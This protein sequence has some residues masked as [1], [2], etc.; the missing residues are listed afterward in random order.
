MNNLTVKFWLN[1]FIPKDVFNKDGTLFSKPRP[2][3]KDETMIPGPITNVPV[4]LPL[5]IP[6]PPVRVDFSDCFTTDNRGFSSDPGASSRLHS[7]IWLS[8]RNGIALPGQD[9]W[10]HESHEVDCED[11][12]LEAKGKGTTDHMKFTEY[13][14]RTSGTTTWYTAK[15]TASARNPLHRTPLVDVT[16]YIDYTGTIECIINA[17]SFV[18]VLFSGFVDDFP[19]FEAYASLNA[20]LPHTIFQAAPP[21]GNTPWNL[22]GKA[23]REVRGLAS[24]RIPANV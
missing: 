13:K 7:E 24:W 19:A 5:P 14:Q 20:G 21:K 22:Y 1:A 10:C 11:G 18:T 9:H 16:P 4:R 3:H 15:L 2:G 23:S 17:N 6:S 12:E 8:F